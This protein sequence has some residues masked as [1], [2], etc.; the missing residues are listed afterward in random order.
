MDFLLDWTKNSGISDKTIT[1][2]ELCLLQLSMTNINC[3]IN[4]RIPI[5]L[6]QN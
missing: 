4:I 6:K 5:K 3:L 2:F 1:T